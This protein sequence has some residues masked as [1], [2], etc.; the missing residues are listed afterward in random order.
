[1]SAALWLLPPAAAAGQLGTLV[2]PGPLSKAHAEVEGVTKCVQCHEAG[3]GVTAER[4]LSC[5]KPIAERIARKFGV[6]RE[7]TDNCVKCHAE[8]GGV[9]A[10]LRRLEPKTFDHAAETGYALEGRHAPLAQACEKCHTTR[11]FLKAQPVCLT[12]H[13]D[14]H[15]PTLGNDCTRCHSTTI[16]FKETRTTFDHETARFGLTGAH[17]TVQCE[18]CHKDAVF[19]GLAFDRCN[20]CHQTPHRRTLGPACTTCH[21]TNAWETRKIDHARTGFTLIGA[22]GKVECA[23]CHQTKI[24]TPLRFD[25][26]S[27]CHENVHRESIKDDCRTCHNET[28]F[29]TAKFDHAERTDFPLAGKHVD[30][31]CR[32]CHKSVSAPD[33]PLAAKVLDY[34]GTRAECATCHED[35]HKGKYG[36]LCD[37]CHRPATFKTAG[38]VHPGHP[39]FFGGSHTKVECA[40]CHA[41]TVD[42]R[43]SPAAFSGPVARATPPDLACRT[44]HEDV[45]LGQVGP[46]CD[47]CHAVDA[48]KFAVPRFSHDRA[49]FPLKGK[50]RD[51]ECAKCHKVET[52][53]YPAGTGKARRLKPVAV[54]CRTC[55]EDPHLGQLDQRCDTCHAP[56]TFKVPAYDH[57]GL[58][59]LFAG[60]HGR[61]PCKSCHKT[62]T[63]AF[64]AGPGTAVRFKVGKTCAACHTQFYGGA[65]AFARLVPAHSIGGRSYER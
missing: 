47:T 46:A 33:V 54:E 42:P 51:V 15:T 41:R 44:C 65:L 26:C 40:K 59:V 5:H 28:G 27:S 57:H 18:K 62:E 32:K 24:T 38:F 64:P 36:R 6:H 20:A 50:H 19:R 56:D 53:A 25:R 63:G 55:H 45:H 22:H 17:R 13:E 48:A 21:A 3:R 12:C 60:F 43:P 10:D 9:D 16:A 4:C 49:A 35:E 30:L 39:E 52:R 23:K 2:S 34:G 14:K 1:V 31:E 37:S 61:L 11:S 7:V 8:H 58:P 29:H